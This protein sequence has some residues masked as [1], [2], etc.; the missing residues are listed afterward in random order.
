[1]QGLALLRRPTHFLLIKV[2]LFGRPSSRQESAFR[3]CPCAATG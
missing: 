2:F 3:A 1:M